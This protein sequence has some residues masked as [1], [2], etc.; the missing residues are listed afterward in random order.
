MSE[1]EYKQVPFHAIELLPCGLCASDSV[2]WQLTDDRTVKFCV[3]CTLGDHVSPIGDDCPLY[4]PPQTFYAAR[5][6]EA[7]KYWNEWM[8]F[9]ASQRK[10]RE[11]K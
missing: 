10:A 5:K 6:I 3:S 2:M 1:I 9:G 7:A 8:R 11:S 4:H